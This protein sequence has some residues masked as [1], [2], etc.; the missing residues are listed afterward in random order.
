[1]AGISESQGEYISLQI[2]TDWCVQVHIFVGE[3][4]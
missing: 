3:Y 2:V 4:S 1:M